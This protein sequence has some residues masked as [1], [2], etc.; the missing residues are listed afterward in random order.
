MYFLLYTHNQLVEGKEKAAIYDLEN[1]TITNI[2]NVIVPIIEEMRSKTVDEIKQKHAPDNP[3]IIDKY[4]H[5]FLEKELGFYTTEPSRFPKLD[6]NFQYPG[7]IQNAIIES[8][9]NTYDEIKVLND[10]DELGCRYVEMRLV[11]ETEAAV[12][13]LHKILTACATS[14]F[15]YVDILIQYN[16]ICTEEFV[17]DLQKRYPK[18]GKILVYNAPKNEEISDSISFVEDSFQALEI[19]QKQTSKYI[20]NIA[21][22]CESLQFNTTYNKKVSIN[23]KGQIKNILKDTHDYGNVNTT[24]LIDVCTSAEFQKWWQI[25]PDKIEQLKDNPLRYA[26]FN[27]FPLKEIAPNKFQ[28]LDV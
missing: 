13:K 19:A 4:V 15:I 25:T 8:N 5:Y 27:P 1:S 10:L 11:I 22:F 9:L 24:N 14:I 21:F 6:T 7:T 16:S 20:V 17:T 12:L 2:P 28:I 3:E 26:L 23:L 18:I